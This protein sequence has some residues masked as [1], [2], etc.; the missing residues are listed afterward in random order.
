MSDYLSPDELVELTEVH[1]RPA[2]V[3]WLQ[4]NGFAYVISAKGH[5]RVLR[6][7]RDAKMGVLAAND[8]GAGEPDFSVFE[9]RA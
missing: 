4:D 8:P 2:Q 6:A 1:T 9:R 3:R 7:H 5:V